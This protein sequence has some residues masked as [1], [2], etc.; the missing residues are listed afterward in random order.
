MDVTLSFQANCIY[1]YKGVENWRT[2]HAFEHGYTKPST[3][4]PPINPIHVSNVGLD[5]YNS[6]EYEYS[7]EED[8]VRLFASPFIISIFKYLMTLPR[9]L[10]LLHW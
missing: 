10:L 3:Q 5:E 9:F 6:D 1:K 2:F 4:G 8:K 7:E